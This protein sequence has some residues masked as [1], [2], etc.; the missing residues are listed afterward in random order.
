MSHKELLDA[1]MQICK[2]HAQRLEFALSHLKPKIPLRAEY[3]R[4]QA[5]E[6][7][8][9]CELFSSRFAKLQDLM[10]AKLFE[11][12]LEYAEEPVP[13]AIIDKLN[14]LE[15]LGCIESAAQWRAMRDIRNH[16]SHEYPTKPDLMA[17]NFND[18]LKAC[19]YLLQCLK[20]IEDYISRI[21]S[22]K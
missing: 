2:L 14:S 9:I 19:D 17:K 4:F 3:F 21:S 12:V 22:Q 10:G 20:N 5:R 6:D 1:V 7:L 16:I 11:L 8:L 13:P 15:K 18:A